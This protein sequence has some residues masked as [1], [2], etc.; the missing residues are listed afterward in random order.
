MLVECSVEPSRR[1]ECLGERV[2]IKGCL[3]EKGGP[4]WPAISLG[5]YE[6]QGGLSGG[7]RH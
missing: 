2:K 5:V 4:T 7:L 6:N 1:S 3:G